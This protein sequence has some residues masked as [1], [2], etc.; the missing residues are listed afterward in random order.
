MGWR[1][2]QGHTKQMPL[3]E[4]GLFKEQKGGHCGWNTKNKAENGDLT[5]E[6]QAGEMLQTMVSFAV[7]SH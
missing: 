4:L 7:R 5:I 1:G 6:I 2:P 3:N